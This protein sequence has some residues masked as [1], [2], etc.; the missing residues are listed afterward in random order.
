MVTLTLP[1]LPSRNSAHAQER[2]LY[3]T[4][5]LL[6]KLPKQTNF[7]G[8]LKYVL[9]PENCERIVSHNEEGGFG[10][11]AVVQK[12]VLPV[13]KTDFDQAFNG[14]AQFGNFPQDRQFIRVAVKIVPSSETKEVL[15]E[16]EALTLASKC[17]YVVN[18]LGCV[19]A[20]SVYFFIENM[21]GN[22][23]DYYKQLAKMGKK[24]SEAEVNCIAY[25]ITSA[26]QYLKSHEIMHRDVK[27]ANI[28]ID[29]KG[30]VKLSDFGISRV[31]DRGCSNYTEIATKSYLPPERCRLYYELQDRLVPE[32][33]VYHYT[34]DVWC[35]GVTL[36]ELAQ[37]I[38]P[39]YPEL[40]H[41]SGTDWNRQL[42]FKLAERGP[43]L[44]GDQWSDSLKTLIADCVR[45]D[46]TLRPSY[47]ELLDQY[48]FLSI[49]STGCFSGAFTCATIAENLKLIEEQRQNY[50]ASLP[51]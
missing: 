13:E 35:L 45:P 33:L 40:E 10:S 38:H 43:E 6:S 23:H 47:D 20:G 36:V 21:S 17:L 26:L 34:S 41:T 28:L 51:P 49:E 1:P 32:Q 24:V 5:G 48:Q 29:E 11:T 7:D 12:I 37:M 25:S 4:G 18:L 39:Y 30:S 16:Y 44:T 14:N 46:P 15:S 50:Y 2:G 19:G 42:Y 3:A 9:N 27:P 8:Q 22:C 31:L